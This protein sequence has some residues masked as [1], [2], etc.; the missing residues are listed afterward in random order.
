MAE[1]EL[2]NSAKPSAEQRRLEKM[3]YKMGRANALL[4]LAAD[5]LQ[6]LQ[7]NNGIAN[8]IG[9]ALPELMYE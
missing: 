1:S 5:E 3:Q 2:Q 6:R 9:Q 7:W 4:T 8:R